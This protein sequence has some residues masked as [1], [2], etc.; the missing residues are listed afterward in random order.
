MTLLL[1][2]AVLFVTGIVTDVLIAL[3][4]EKHFQPAGLPTFFVLLV[5]VIVGGWRLAV[6]ITEPRTD[7]AG[8]V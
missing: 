2:F 3:E 1:A 4:V 7:T 5:I 8:K 6:R